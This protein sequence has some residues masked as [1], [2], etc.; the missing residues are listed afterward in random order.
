MEALEQIGK[1][2]EF[3]EG[4]YYSN[5]LESMRKDKKF[6]VI[7]FV[8]LSE[9]DA[10]L[11]ESILDNPE[12][13]I[14]AFELAVEDMDIEEIKGFKVRFKNMPETAKIAIRDIRSKHLGKLVW[15]EGVVKQKSDVR[16]QVTSARFEC[17]SC[18]NVIN[19]LQLDS[20][21][22]EPSRCGCGRKGRFN[23][24]SKE[25]V[26]AQMMV[27]EEVTENIEGGDQPK[28]IKVFL[29][30]D[31]VS[32]L[33]DKRSNPGSKVM[34]VG[35]VKEIPIV[36][37]A[38]AKTTRFDIIL[39]A[40]YIE[41]SQES[42]QE[43][44]INPEEEKEILDLSQDPRLVQRLVNSIAPSI[45]GY[46]K[47]KEALLLQLM[48]GVRKVRGDKA[49]S[50][51]DIHILLVG[52]PGAGK[53]Q[54]LKRV[55]VIAPKARYVAGQGVSGPGI[56]A[57][58]VR[59]EF[60]KGWSLE[61]GALVLASDGICCIDEMD[62]MSNEDRSAMHEALEQQTVS[63]SKANIQ[64]T[65]ISRTTVLAAANPK[66]GRFDPYGIV[67]EQIDLPP[68]L[69]NR[70]DLIF[71]IK[72]IPDQVYDE[73]LASHLLGLHQAP[74]MSEPEIPTEF[75]KKYVS[76]AR[77]RSKPV[78]TDSALQEIKE[79]YLKMRSSGGGE[80]SIKAV[81]ISARQLEALVRLSEASA[82]IRLSDKVTKRDARR[83]IELLEYCL[84]Q[85][86]FDKETG[87]IDIDRITTGVSASQRSH[88]LIVKEIISELEGKIGKAIP[89]DD[90]IEE[91][92][93][94]EIPEERVE[95]SIEK[96]K[97][98]GDIFEPRRGFISRI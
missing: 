61:A 45:F 50:R 85:I 87:K 3:V 31:L 57:S 53:S 82:K 24:L 46:E 98:S 9:F 20:N 51:G 33:S 52:D 96:L 14:R 66:F 64:A 36:N 79:F 37:N 23:M 41:A 75:L 13:T 5:I 11:A 68:T 72:D 86:G 70:F 71:P 92:R 12:D 91:A 60:L 26:D 69:I 10:E 21:F 42:F 97:R 63:I 16:P 2:H 90:V 38:G 47:V 89:I 74:D 25:L 39:E 80:E 65:L 73:K 19:V 49:V 44:V 15:T 29:K 93:L 78:L 27:L 94:R 48:G 34:F 4:N 76:Y 30:D 18:G 88:I 1:F 43:V 77:Q 56:T 95:E 83:G 55:T 59:D 6:L 62:K 32:P 22:R 84:M 17:P 67:A 40:N 35:I 8:K 7:D 81:P 54:L 58:V 28:R